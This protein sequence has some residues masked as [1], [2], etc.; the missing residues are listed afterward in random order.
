M[1]RYKTNGDTDMS[2]GVGFTLTT[3]NR[4]RD[5]ILDMFGV[6]RVAHV[7]DVHRAVTVDVAHRRDVVD[8]VDKVLPLVGS[9]NSSKVPFGT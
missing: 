5:A 1:Q 4:H 2:G 9:A 7:S 6:D 3:F 8:D